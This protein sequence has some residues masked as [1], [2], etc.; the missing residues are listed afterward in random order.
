MARIEA[1]REGDGDGGTVYLKFSF[2]TAL[3]IKRAIVRVA[4]RR[5]SP[6]LPPEDERPLLALYDAIDQVT[7][8]PGAPIPQ[9]RG[10][11]PR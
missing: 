8:W 9:D 6:L 1:E 7:H 3:A 5:E 10:L 11:D 4:S 2:Y